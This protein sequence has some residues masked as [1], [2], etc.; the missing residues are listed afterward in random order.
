MVC[1]YLPLDGWR[2]APLAAAVKL[3]VAPAFTVWLLG[4]VVTTGA[5]STVNV[6]PAE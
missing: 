3:T 6:A 5:V 2:G 1:T 4:L